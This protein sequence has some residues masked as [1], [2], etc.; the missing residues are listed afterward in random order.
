MIERIIVGCS[1]KDHP[2]TGEI[3]SRYSGAS[4]HYETGALTKAYNYENPKKTLRLDIYKGPFLKNCPCTRGV[5]SCGYYILS[6]VFGCPMSCSYCVLQEYLNVEGITA[7]INLEDMF[8]QTESFLEKHKNRNFRIGTGELADSLALEPGLGFAKPLVEFFR[9]KQNA[10]FELKTKSINIDT[11]ID[12][13]HGGK[14]VIGFSV[15]PFSLAKQIEKGS[16]PVPE[17]INAA[18]IAVE[19]GYKTA[20]HFDPIIDLDPIANPEKSVTPYQETVD[21]I[22]NNVEKESIAWISLGALRFNK[23]LHRSIREANPGGKLMRAE[24]HPGLDGKMRYFR[25]RRKALQ[26]EVARM[27][28]MHHHQAPIYLCMEDTHVVNH[29]LGSCKLPFG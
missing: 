14:T 21:C 9:D 4:V 24:F 20:F 5:L 13:N 28:R 6:P 7:Y 11:V 29:V 18:K 26:K 8:E 17:R 19:A 10:T 22:Y 3:I 2:R 1:A 25:H 27:I 16:A 15:G 23:K 12:A